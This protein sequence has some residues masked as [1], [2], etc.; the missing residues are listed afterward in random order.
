M[1]LAKRVSSS[2]FLLIRFVRLFSKFCCLKERKEHFNF[3]QNLGFQANT[4]K[5]VILSGMFVGMHTWLSFLSVLPGVLSRHRVRKVPI[6]PC[7]EHIVSDNACA[8]C[9]CSPYKLIGIHKIL[10]K[11]VTDLISPKYRCQDLQY[12]YIFSFAILNKS[13]ITMKMKYH[14][15]IILFFP[16]VFEKDSIRHFIKSLI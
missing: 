16:V 15:F 14:P 1:S 12:I 9:A 10:T 4:W 5:T 3:L 11:T 13:L 8:K 6:Q 2:V 7:A